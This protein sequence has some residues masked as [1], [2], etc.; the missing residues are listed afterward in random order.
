M[1]HRERIRIREGK[2]VVLEEDFARVDVEATQT[3]D[4]INFVAL[5]DVD[6]LLFYKPHHLEVERAGRRLT[7]FF[8]TR[9][10]RQAA[11]PSR[12]W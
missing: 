10:L 6:P 3:V 7:S 11:S 12:K 2:Y 9:L 1:I 8:A 5:K 4:I